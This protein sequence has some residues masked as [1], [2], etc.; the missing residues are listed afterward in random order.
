MP[1]AVSPET[2]TKLQQRLERVQRQ[3]RAFNEAEKKR[4]RADDARRKI[5]AGALALEHF[6]KNPGTDFAKTLLRLLDEYVRPYERH[7]FEFLPVRE[8]SPAPPITGAAQTGQID[9]TEAAE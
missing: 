7:L 4:V 2:K 6:E 3:L 5:I 9:Q 8:V 1:R